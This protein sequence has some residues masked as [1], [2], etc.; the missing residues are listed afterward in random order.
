MK[1]LRGCSLGL[2]SQTVALGRQYGILRTG[3]PPKAQGK[4]LRREAARRAPQGRVLQGKDVARAE[5][6]ADCFSV[7]PSTPGLRQNCVRTSA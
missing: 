2:V 1:K 5:I 3:P 6:S 4:V 7:F